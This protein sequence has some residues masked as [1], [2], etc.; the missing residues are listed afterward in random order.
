MTVHTINVFLENVPKPTL[1]TDLPRPQQRIE[2][3]EQLIYCNALLLQDSLSLPS[4]EQEPTLDK[5][6]LAWLVEIKNDPIEQDRLQW[7]A[8]RMVEKFIQEGI[9]D[10]T[11]IAEIVALGPIF[12]QEPYRK[13]LSSFIKEL[14]DSLLLNVDLLQGLVQLVQSSSPGYLVSDD[15]VKILGLLRIC[16]QGTH[17]QSTEHPYYLTLAIS[18]VLDFMADHKTQDLDRILEHEPLS[19]VLSGLKGSTN[20]YLMYQACYAFQAL[21]YVPNNET[22]LQAVLRHSQGV[23]EGVVKITA[24]GKLDLG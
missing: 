1:R 4:T 20:P 14:D 12:Q 3:T 13:L 21:Q 16:L 23:V 9:K 5:T 7:L 17:Q 6:E 15:L 24:L 22:V 19:G 11:K 18:R 2:R 10:S 8:N